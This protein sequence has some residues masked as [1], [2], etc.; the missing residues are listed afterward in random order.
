[1]TDSSPRPMGNR[2]VLR[3]PE[4][5]K[6][7]AAQAVSDVGDGMTFMALLLLVNELTHS[8]A[9]LAVLSIAVAVPS[10]IGG[11]IAGAYADRLDRRRIMIVSDIVRAGL[12]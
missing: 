2:D 4:F 5:R 9:A 8:P 1:M 3:L 7:F 10:M 11:V 6:I 12:V